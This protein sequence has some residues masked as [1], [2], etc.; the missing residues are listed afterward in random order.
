M[1]YADEEDEESM[2]GFC[3][4]CGEELRPNGDCPDCDEFEDRTFVGEAP[5]PLW[6]DPDAIE[7]D[8]DAAHIDD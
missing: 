1:T 8:D 4:E 3:E 7:G 6:D 5:K 2:A